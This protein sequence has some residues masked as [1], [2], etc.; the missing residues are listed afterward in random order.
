MNTIWQD[1]KYAFRMMRARPGFTAAAVISLAVGIGACAAIFSVVDAAL[2]RSLPFPQSHRIVQMREVNE[3]G[4]LIPVAEPN[5]IDARERN[6]SLEALAQMS[7][8]LVTVAGG[9][10]P[11]RARAFWVSGDFFRALGVEPA[12]GRFFLPEESKAGGNNAVAVVSYGFWQRLLGAK[13]D[14]E[15]TTLNV[16]DQI[17]TVV[18]VMPQG[19]AY[20]EGAEVWLP[21]EMFPPQTSRTAHNWTVIGRLRPGASLEQARADLS[22][23]G[24]QF[25][26]DYGKDVDAVDLALIPLQEYMARNVRSGLL[27]LLGAVG[28][29]LLIA[30]ANV[31]N[32]LLAQAAARQK[33]LAVRSAL[34]ATRLRLARQFI[35]ESMALAL[36]AAAAGVALAFWGVD[37]LVALNRDNLPRASE[38]GVNGRALFFA[39][40]L[41]MI[42][43]VGLGLVPALRS[44]GRDLQSTLK[45]SG[46]SQSSNAFSQ[47]LR[48]LLVISQ[49]ALTLVLLIG[50]GLLARSFIELLRVDPGFRPES[51]VAMDI[52]VSAPKTDQQKQQ[53]ARFHQQ[54]LERLSRI[55]GVTAAG[56]VSSLPMT[57]GGSNGAFLIDNNPANTGYA[58]YRL[59]SG[60]Y[61]EAMGIP[62]LRGRLFEQSDG[63]QSPHVAVISQSLAEKHWPG[64]DPIGKRI[65][66]GN[67]DGDLRLLN[68][69]GVVGDVRERG[70]ES[71]IRPTVYA[72]AVQ[73]PQPSNYSLVARANQNPAALIAAMR[74]E[75]EGL[76]AEVPAN[77]RTIEQIFSSS[78][79][80]RRFSL[81]LFSVFGGAALLLAVTGIYGVMSYAVAQRTREIGIRMA[82]GA[83]GSDAL[84]MVIKQGMKLV[85]V[86]VAIGAAASAAMASLIKSMVFKVSATDPATFAALTGLLIAVALAACYIPARRATK[87][88][89]MIAL[90]H[91]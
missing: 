68:V 69:V 54:L 23:I 32:L 66:F 33:E 20:P 88:D 61:F 76:N 53:L 35:T 24:R 45:E 80:E 89:P 73:R 50:A 30:C 7:G 58:E 16:S 78:L 41:S 49:V 9:S 2:L 47:S 3:K 72:Y 11:A 84:R 62:L 81:V 26:Q 48:S 63:P 19:L 1:L 85:A 42:V 70:L 25:K 28:F 52:S 31:A 71:D 18:G 83:S 39:L 6:N 27:I 21:R 67:M 13:A 87:V 15:G 60:E 29:L 65:Q 8:G 44:A 90:R 43:A 56:G 40:A 37:A 64:E 12:A 38:I 34:G 36:I 5:F 91:E 17:V 59:A 46:R 82:L 75:L 86:G 22:A 10:Q 14:L 55:P 79:N 74:S 57:G 51:A 4:A 77:F